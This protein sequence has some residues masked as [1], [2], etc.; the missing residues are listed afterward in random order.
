[1]YIILGLLLAASGFAIVAKSEWML[2]NF[3]RIGFFEDHLG[4]EGGSRLGYKLIGMMV[5]FIGVMIAT[6][7]ISG[8]LGWILS[9]LMQYYK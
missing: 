7:L 4:T 6:D 2:N 5:I 1:M 9:P 3:G 8:F